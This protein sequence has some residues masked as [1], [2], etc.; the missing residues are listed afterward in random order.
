MYLCMYVLLG[1]KVQLNEVK[2][3]N[4]EMAKHS[5]FIEQENLVMKVAW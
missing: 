5:R 2:N 4:E 1:Y 3:S